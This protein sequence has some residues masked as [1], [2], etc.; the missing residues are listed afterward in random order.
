MKLGCVEVVARI[1]MVRDKRASDGDLADEALGV[2][3][4]KMMMTFFFVR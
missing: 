1:M 3:T 4:K 2:M